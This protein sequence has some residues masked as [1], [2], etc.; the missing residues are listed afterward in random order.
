MSKTRIHVITMYYKINV[1]NTCTY[2]ICVVRKPHE[3]QRLVIL[4]FE[5]EGLYYPCNSLLDMSLAY[6]MKF[7]SFL[8]STGI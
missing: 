6:R 1:S 4:E 3:C 7:K 5:V 8:P 2:D